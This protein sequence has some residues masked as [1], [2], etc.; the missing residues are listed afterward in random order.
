[1]RGLAR[2]R[3]DLLKFNFQGDFI[4]WDQ[5]Y[6]EGSPTQLYCFETGMVL[7]EKITS[8][9]PVYLEKDLQKT[10]HMR[11]RIIRLLPSEREQYN[12]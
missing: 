10:R 12:N 5:H 3:E 1:M 6:A 7:W 9:V 8:R 11:R 2:I 4:P